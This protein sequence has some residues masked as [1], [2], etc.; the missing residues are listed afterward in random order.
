MG[1]VLKSSMIYKLHQS[2]RFNFYQQQQC[3]EKYNEHRNININ[4]I[5]AN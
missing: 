4:K 2:A 5:D 1:A 3:V